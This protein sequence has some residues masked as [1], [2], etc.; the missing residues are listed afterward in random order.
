MSICAATPD[1]PSMAERLD[2]ALCLS[3]CV[4]VCVYV[5]VVCVSVV[6]CCVYSGGGRADLLC[7]QEGVAR[8]AL[9]DKLEDLLLANRALADQHC[10]LLPGRITSG[11]EPTTMEGTKRATCG[12]EPLVWRVLGLG[13]AYSDQIGA[14][15]AAAG[16]AAVGRARSRAEIRSKPQMQGGT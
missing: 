7:L 11:C 8:A 16:A 5:C 15:I 12:G 3:V 9:P 14:G 2:Q 4:C 10:Q 6:L 13:S 1:R